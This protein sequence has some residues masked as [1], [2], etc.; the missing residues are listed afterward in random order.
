MDN[1]YTQ[2][3]ERLNINKKEVEEI[4][5]DYITHVKKKCYPTQKGK[6]ILNNSEN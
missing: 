2:V 5:K 4:Y 1:I 6:Y 3:A